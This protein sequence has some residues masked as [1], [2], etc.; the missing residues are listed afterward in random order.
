MDQ[1][2]KYN[3]AHNASTEA[4]FAY[5]FWFPGNKLEHRSWVCIINI[6]VSFSA[7]TYHVMS[8]LILITL[9]TYSASQ[10]KI[11]QYRI[12]HYIPED[13]QEN[14]M[15]ETIQVLKGLIKEHMYL[16]G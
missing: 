1:L 12:K 14:Q 15:D 2:I 5:E 11:L 3:E 10:L 9:L 4:H 8:I 6:L 13:L 16:I 7:L